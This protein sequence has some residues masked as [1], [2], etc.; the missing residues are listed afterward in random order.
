MPASASQHAIAIT[1][2]LTALPQQAA[3]LVVEVDASISQGQVRDLLGVNKGPTFS[4]KQ[5]GVSYD[6]S[7]LYSRF[8]VSQARLHDTGI[9]LCTV[10]KA[11]TKLNAS[12]SPATAVNGC[13]LTPDGGIPRFVW[14]P[15][16]SADSDLNN[17]D[18]YDF[19]SADEQIKKS[20]NAGAKIY[21]G[22]AQNYNGPNDTADPV[23][24]AKVSANIYK[25]VIGV[26]KPSAGIA[27]DPAYVEVHNEPDGGFW[28]GD[29][30]TFIT[31]YQETTQRVRA[32]AAAAGKT[33]VIGGPGFTRDV[34]TKSKQAGNPANGFIAA[35]GASSLDFYSAH[36]YDKC[37]QATLSASASFLRN[38]RAL[39]NSQGGSGKPLHI[40]EW[41][42]GL[43]TECGN[44]YY[45]DQRTQSFGSG[46]LTL[47]QDPAQA[48]DAAHF[49]AG[50]TVMSL[51]DFTSVAGSVR[52]NP[53]AWAFWAHSQ[54]K[55]ATALG[56]QVCT[57]SSNCVAGYAADGS[58]L[59]AISG[60]LNGKQI[61]IVTNDSSAAVSYT[62][63]A[64]GLS[65][66]SA[67]ITI[68]TPPQGAQDI[69]ASGNPVAVDSTT[70]DKL[71]AT[72]SSDARPAQ[73]ISA[74][75]VQLS[76]SIPAHSLQL[77]E[78]SSDAGSAPGTAQIDCLLNWGE[79]NYPSLLS[80]AGQASKSASPYY[81]RYYPGTQA[82]LGVSGSDQ[83]LYYLANAASL[84][85]LGL[86]SG[87]ISS[88]GCQ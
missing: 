86:A 66:A 46:L 25:H 15:S 44:S 38:V 5:A 34:L 42:I 51:F 72:V 22:L 18:N 8:G 80:P 85:D 69:A 40:S 2:L 78:L 63:R 73:P 13:T 45:A 74:G 61:S 4:A 23:A 71:L 52:V 27:V 53:A 43:G 31:L 49:Y 19:S 36:L 6:A 65:G 77:I 7:N 17:P 10:Y 12:T 88:A 87:W 41:N 68:R 33:V 32:A 29:T 48:I 54:L 60:K 21:L 81:Y 50:V 26:F 9:D 20:I 1:L 83:H 55:G 35:V 79:K 82:Y 30:A 3:N 70:L 28:R 37:A 24:W 56:T 47:M 16:S 84:L 58:A 14:T 67:N 39:V 57:D 59:Q 11:A 76:M 62:W 64:K 75:A